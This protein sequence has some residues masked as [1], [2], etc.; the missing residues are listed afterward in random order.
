MPQDPPAPA[1][2]TQIGTLQLT[3]LSV[4]KDTSTIE[5]QSFVKPSLAQPTVIAQEL[6][7]EYVLLAQTPTLTLPNNADATNG[8]IMIGA[9][10]S[11]QLSPAQQADAPAQELLLVSVQHAMMPTLTSQTDANPATQG[12]EDHLQQEAAKSTALIHHA[13]VMPT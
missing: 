2:Q 5:L 8:S 4:T 1:A 6:Y 9:P 7:Q 10:N 11:A 3:A 13:L 12:T